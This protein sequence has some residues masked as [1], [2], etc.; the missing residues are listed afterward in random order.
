MNYCDQM[1]FQGTFED[2]KIQFI[3]CFDQLKSNKNFTQY[4]Q[5]NWAM[6][7]LEYKV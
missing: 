2:Q 5:K 4:N 6:I 7:N 3:I 1:W